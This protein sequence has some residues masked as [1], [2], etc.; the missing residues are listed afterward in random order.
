MLKF[1][2]RYFIFSAIIFVVEVFIAIFIHDGIIRPYVGDFLV[3]IL[4]YCFI[5][6]FFN[7]GVLPTAIFVLLFSYTIESLQ[8]FKVVEKLGLK[9]YKIVRI[10]MGTS[11]EWSDI[12]VYTLGIATVLI[13]EKKINGKALFK[14]ANA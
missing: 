2:S 4:I 3:V 14:R 12:L 7:F 8:Y 1:H 6:S 13:I 11:F 10:I 5:K 9:N